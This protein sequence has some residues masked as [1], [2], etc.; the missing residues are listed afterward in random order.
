MENTNKESKVRTIKES[1]SNNV[2][3]KK[4][5]VIIVVIVIALAIIIP[6]SVYKVSI[7]PVEKGNDKEIVVEIE[8]GSSTTAIAHT[9]K[10]NETVKS[11]F[12]FK[13]K[14]KFGG[15]DG[16]FQA[17]KYGF[18]KDM[19]AEE[20]MKMMSKGET[21]G[22]MFTLIE[23]TNS[24]KIG[25]ALEQQGIIKAKDFYKELEHGKF[26][27]E[28]LKNAPKGPG[29][30]D[31][32]LCPETYK[33]EPGESA[34]SIIDK[35]L[36]QFEKAYNE[37]YKLELKGK[38]IHKIMTVASIVERE[39]KTDEDKENV[40]SVIYNRLEIGM[41][42]QMDSILAYITGEDKIK[43]SLDDTKVDSNYNPYQNKGLPPGPICSPGE[44]AIQAAI[45]PPETKYIYFVATEKLDGT[46]VFSET[47]DEFLKDKK[48]FDKAYREY[49]KK[50]PGKK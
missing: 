47:Y 44:K 11:E 21:L 32:F 24:K 8:P 23:G 31:G 33:F 4:N 49:I 6:I 12:F 20:Q 40:A 27:Y 43:A 35:M 26:D 36:K 15:Y 1:G 7:S 10:E 34:H 41:P 18:S 14:S 9:L 22:T 42:L 38:D 25:E 28:F 13:L 48:K 46:N 5:I 16:K 37:K 45:N 30:L 29:R 17:G 3:R 39:A 50:N 19:S 2:N